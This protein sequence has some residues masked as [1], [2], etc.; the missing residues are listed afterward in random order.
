MGFLNS[1]KGS[2]ISEYFN[3]LEDVGSYKAGNMCEVSLYDDRLEISAPFVKQEVRLKYDQ[4]RDVFHGAK[5]ELTEKNKSVIGR[6]VVGGVLLGPLGAIVGAVS[7][8]G[9]KLKQDSKLY[10][11]ISYANSNGEDKILQFEDTRKYKGKKIAN[12]LKSLA[13]INSVSNEAV[14]DL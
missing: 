12:Q 8:T 11:I 7:G 5:T 14:L 6:A 4:V 1:K 9:K 3:L 13:G 2:I 10:F